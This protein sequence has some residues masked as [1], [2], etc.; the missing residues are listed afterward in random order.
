LLSIQ[1]D[2][3]R[4]G[5]SNYIL[6]NLVTISDIRKRVD[7]GVEYLEG[8]IELI[9]FAEGVGTEEIELGEVAVFE[10]SSCGYYG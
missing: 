1:V 2:K 6:E 5:L 9:L 7:F 8:A 10:A 4:L 3:R